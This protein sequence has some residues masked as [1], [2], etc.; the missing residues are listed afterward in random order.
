MLNYFTPEY[1]GPAFELFGAGHLLVLSILFFLCLGVVYGLPKTTPE[2]HRRFRRTL[3]WTLILSELSWQIWNV[4]YGTWSVDIMLPLHLCGITG[5]LAMY[6][7]LSDDFRF[8]E[9][10]YLLG[11]GGAFQTVMTPDAGIYGLPHFRAI[12]TFVGHGGIILAGLYL[13]VVEKKHPT[14]RSIW[15]VFW[16]GN[17][18]MVAVF[19]INLALGSNYMFVMHKPET[20]SLLD[21][22]P[23]WPWYIIPVELLAILTCLLLYL[24]FGVR[25][26]QS[27]KN[28]GS[29]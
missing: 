27:R 3:G 16:I 8:Y 21:I 29:L 4:V 11:V 7:L 28:G 22:L 10:I 24:P 9:F 2:N 15:R 25:A 19:F 12:Q 14:L 23:A 17:V 6:T 1:T 5:Y 18:Y 13:V 20:A 26:W